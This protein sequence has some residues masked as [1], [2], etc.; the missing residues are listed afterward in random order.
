MLRGSLAKAVR[1]CT[2]LMVKYFLAEWLTR[3]VRCTKCLNLLLAFSLFVTLI[4][5]ASGD[6]NTQILTSG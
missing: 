5:V 6:S 3:I 4:V 1:Y 2:P